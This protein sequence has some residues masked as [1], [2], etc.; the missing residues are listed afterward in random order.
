MSNQDV[1]KNCKK[2]RFEMN[3]V[4]NVIAIFSV[5]CGEYSECGECG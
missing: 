1:A 5:E 4:E 2:F 3:T